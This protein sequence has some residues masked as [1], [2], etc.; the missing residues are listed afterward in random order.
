VL[1]WER[2]EITGSDLDS[3]FVRSGPHSSPGGDSCWCSGVRLI[4]P[5]PS[6][7]QGAG[8]SSQL[9]WFELTHSELL[10]AG[11]QR[12]TTAMFNDDL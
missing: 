9:C 7:G 1:M 8:A 11:N 2:A 3:S 5:A 6:V 4:F 10:R 12:V